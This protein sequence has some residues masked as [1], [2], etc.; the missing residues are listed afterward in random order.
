M[1]DQ[2]VYIDLGHY[3]TKCAYQQSATGRS[4]LLQLS[5]QKGP[6]FPTAFHIS[7]GDPYHL[8]IGDEALAAATD[9]P[10]GL[11]YGLFDVSDPLMRPKVPV[12][13]RFGALFSHIAQVYQKATDKT[14]LE[15]VIS[16]WDAF[17]T[18]QQ[19]AL[20]VAAQIAGI[21]RVSFTPAPQAITK[22]AMLQEENIDYLTILDLGHRNCH[23]TTMRVNDKKIIELTAERRL[24]YDFQQTSFNQ[25]FIRKLAD[26]GLI[27][28]MAE[29]TPR[30]LER[31]SL[32]IDQLK[33]A[34]SEKPNEPT[35][36]L[37]Y[38]DRH[39]DLSHTFI[40]EVTEAFAEQLYR[41]I[42]DSFNE[43]CRV[44]SIS[45][46]SLCLCGLTARL[47]GLAQC[48]EKKLAA[49]LVQF[50]Q[51]A[52]AALNGEATDPDFKS[53]DKKRT[54]ELEPGK[55]FAGYEIIRKIGQG[56][57]GTVWLARHNTMDVELALKTLH[58]HLTR[59]ESA[60]SRFMSEIRNSAQLKHPN[61]IRA[62]NAGIE[63]GIYYLVSEF[64]EGQEVES[65]LTQEGRLS[66]EMALH[67]A[68]EVAKG[69]K[70]AWDK[71]SMLHR[72]IKPENIM[73]GAEDRVFIMDM[74]IAKRML[75]SSPGITS[76]DALLGTPHYMSPEQI[77]G[78]GKLD[79]RSDMYSLGA[80]LFHMVTGTYPYNGDSI[81]NIATKHLVDPVPNPA[82]R[83][84]ELSAQLTELIESLMQK[85]PDGRPNT[86]QEVIDS[87]DQILGV[88]A[89]TMIIDR[90][91]ASKDTIKR[92]INLGAA[93]LTAI[94][95]T[96][97]Y[98]AYFF[99]NQ[100]AAPEQ[101]SLIGFKFDV[102]PPDTRIT[103][104]HNGQAVEKYQQVKTD[105]G[106]FTLKPGKYTALIKKDGYKP[107][108][109]EF[110]V[111]DNHTALSISLE[112][113]TGQLKLITAPDVEVMAVPIQ[114]G[115]IITLGQTDNRGICTGDLRV[116][117]YKLQLTHPQYTAEEL[118]IVIRE[119]KLTEKKQEMFLKPGLL[120]IQSDIQY[121]V[122][123]DGAM[124]G[125]TNKPIDSLEVGQHKLTISGPGYRPTE[126]TVTVS[127]RPSSPLKSPTLEMQRG[128]ISVE[129][130]LPPIYA[131][132]EILPNT[133]EYQINDQPWRTVSRPV[134]LQDIP[135]GTH[136]VKIR[137]D[138]FST[139]PSEIELEVKDQTTTLS[140]FR[141]VPN[142]ATLIVQTNPANCDIYNNGKKIGS[143]N[144]EIP[145]SAFLDHQL[146]ISKLGYKPVTQKVY[147]KPGESRTITIPELSLQLG[148]LKIATTIDP[149]YNLI[150]NPPTSGSIRLDDEQG[151]REM[152]IPA[153]VR[154]IP[155]RTYKV[156][157][158]A[159]DFETELVKTS[160]VLENQTST[161]TFVL[162]P[163]PIQF[164]IDANLKKCT[165]SDQTGEVLGKTGFP[166]RLRPFTTHRLTIS[167]PHHKSLTID[168]TIKDRETKGLPAP[169][170]LERADG[171]ITSEI[172]HPVNC[173]M[174][175]IPLKPGKFRVHSDG[176]NKTE[177]EEV[178]LSKPFWAGHTEVTQ[179]DFKKIMG[180]NPS[181]F[182]TSPRL[183]VE[184]V[185][186]SEAQSFCRK[187]TQLEVENGRLLPGDRYRLPT[188]AEWEYIA[189]AGTQTPFYFGN[190]L[191]SANANV[192]ATYSFDGKVRGEFRGKTTTVGSFNPNAWGFYDI[193]GNVWEWCQDYYSK[194]YPSRAVDPTGPNVGID[195]I[196]RG[197]SW[198]TYPKDAQNHN[199]YWK[200]SS[201]KN[202]QIG[203][204]IV[205]ELTDELNQSQQGSEQP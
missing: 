164:T 194:V 165:I 19:Q 26:E 54:V 92:N 158:V 45:I 57:M 76:E 99:L 51:P 199:R 3:Y 71:H 151:W 66:E 44:H 189:R 178:T 127:D 201:F 68:R 122:F 186:W 154:D 202:N 53:P 200:N 146:T 147:L 33:Q 29:Q 7:N 138:G 144:R 48:L 109:K 94:C 173:T 41:R 174:H 32:S 171:P 73:L 80:S 188:E 78:N 70:Y 77:R 21:A 52:F 108:T 181:F 125:T 155:C 35:Y 86:W 176:N 190:N 191:T 18:E 85:A 142:P 112:E 167:A 1:T 83:N 182:T 104:L 13:E 43:T 75:E 79:A 184:Q 179:Q 88:D 64:I 11:V 38:L 145:M 81:I 129:L 117:S 185:S 169:L 113:I 95:S 172:W 6:L 153:L 187:L 12:E 126:L 141:V 132:R 36:S 39:L 56:G 46:P 62:Q 204:R 160:E 63:D 159:T 96:L 103:I 119:D 9:D 120:V 139:E 42:Q 50:N 183:P 84:P 130:R 114:G 16:H 82:E 87:I 195:Y 60:V 4:V 102:T 8:L 40:D 203:F 89:R 131:D 101:S 166:I 72:D 136:K 105:T 74:G 180:Y 55:K 149:A 175:L 28:S 34:L 59:D 25:I 67:I 156:N 58:P 5:D 10:N 31:L 143:S 91:S 162:R 20:T 134:L 47:P 205:L 135:C 163:T 17:S 65:L 152:A 157:L 98:M 161:L 148:N 192:D 23:M 177:I 100:P 196:L 168:V 106:L 90:P 123:K 49:H 198:H 116:G 14:P 37:A 118:N 115:N 128:T 111:S 15:A 24:T 97:I 193:H 110:P 2:K 107:L 93:A 150:E 121:E 133:V 137:L 30:E 197:G 124:I 140:N 61:I 170:F 27:P 22:A 69:L